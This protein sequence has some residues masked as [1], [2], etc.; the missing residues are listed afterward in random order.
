M[1]AMRQGRP[2]ELYRRPRLRRAFLPLLPEGWVRYYVQA[3]T[4]WWYRGHFL[5]TGGTPVVLARAGILRG[6][7][8]TFSDNPVSLREMK[9]GGAVTV[10]QPVVND[11]RIIT[12][13]GP[14]AAKAFADEFVRTLTAVV[15]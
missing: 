7:K 11:Q 3:G 13:D 8:V 6:R 10:K 5:T 1:P 9:T 2:A 14:A 4:R 15:W 12:A